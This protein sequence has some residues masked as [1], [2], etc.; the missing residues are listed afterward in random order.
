MRKR[1]ST[2]IL[3]H[4]GKQVKTRYKNQ[5]WLFEEDKI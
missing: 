4:I 2:L 3:L 5:L 1:G